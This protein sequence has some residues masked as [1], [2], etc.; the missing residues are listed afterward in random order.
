MN[1]WFGVRAV[2][3]RARTFDVDLTGNKLFLE[4]SIAFCSALRDGQHLLRT[5]N[6]GDS[7]R[8]IRTLGSSPKF[9]QCKQGHS[10]GK[11]TRKTSSALR[12]S[13][14]EAFFFATRLRVFSTFPDLVRLATG[15]SDAAAHSPAFNRD[16][17]IFTSGESSLRAFVRWRLYT[18]KWVS[19]AILTVADCWKIR[20]FCC[21]C[22]CGS[23]VTGAG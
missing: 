17:R 19:F 4:V 2:S 1:A 7:H 20:E 23:G 16:W 22:W 13:F 14:A 18:R 6:S 9:L 8:R 12:G 11:A 21:D 3:E 10:S 5:I 15:P